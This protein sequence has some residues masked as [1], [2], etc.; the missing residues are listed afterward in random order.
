MPDLALPCTGELRAAEY[1]Q[2]PEFTGNLGSPV[3]LP[4]MDLVLLVQTGW[5]VPPGW[6]AP[7]S[8]GLMST[9]RAVVGYRNLG[10]GGAQLWITWRA[11]DQRGGVERSC[12]WLIATEAPEVF[13]VPLDQLLDVEHGQLLDGPEPE[14]AGDVHAYPWYSTRLIRALRVYER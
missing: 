11:G 3:L 1:R 2:T 7:P 9:Y 13:D 8:R 6:T 10:E 14:R 12:A 4:W 5:S